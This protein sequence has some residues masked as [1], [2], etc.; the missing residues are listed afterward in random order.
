MQMSRAVLDASAIIALLRDEPGAEA[1]RV[2]VPDALVSAVNISEVGAKFAE[3]GM[4]EADIRGAIG[5][6]G[7]EV[8]AFDEAAAHATAWLRGQTRRLGLSLGDRAC[9]ALGATRGLPVLTTD[10]S[11]AGVD[12]G[13]DVRV[14][15]GDLTR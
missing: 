3:R 8:V 5:T 14:V 6:L 2:W 12:I 10:R 7:L 13:V 1:V 9:L 11:W 15:R 4:K